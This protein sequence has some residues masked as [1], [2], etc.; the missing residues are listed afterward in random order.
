MI[1]NISHDV[2][3]VWNLH[4]FFYLWTLMVVLDLNLCYFFIFDFCYGTFICKF[5]MLLYVIL[6]ELLI[7]TL[8]LNFI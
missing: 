1:D 3:E 6:V 8:L 4:G 5:M 2:L 7:V